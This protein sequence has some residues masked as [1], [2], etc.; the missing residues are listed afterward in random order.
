MLLAMEDGY[1]LH[2]LIDSA[3][4]PPDSFNRSVSTL[5]GLIRNHR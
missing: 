4:T 1:R 5:Q 3:S 2:E